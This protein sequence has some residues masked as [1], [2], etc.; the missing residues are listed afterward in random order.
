M[1][2]QVVRS[3]GRAATGSSVVRF[4]P[5]RLDLESQELRHDG[6]PVRLRHQPLTV[7]ALLASQPGRVLTREEIQLAVWG[8]DTHVDFEQGINYC[9]KEIRAALGDRA[10][11]PRYVETLARR[12]YRFIASVQ[13]GDT[14]EAPRAEA[15]PRPRRVGIWASAGAAVALVSVMALLAARLADRP[16]PPERLTVAVLPFENLSGDPEQDY[17]SEGLTE[18]VIARLGRLEPARLSVIA[19]SVAVDYRRRERAVDALGEELGVD[20]VLEGSVRLP[21]GRV[22][23]T[24]RLVRTG[25]KTQ[26]WADNLDLEL[27]DVVEVQRLIAQS[28]AARIPLTTTARRGASARGPGKVDPEAYRLYLRGRYFWNKWSVSALRRSISHFEDAI[29]RQPDYALAHAGLADAYVALADQSPVDPADTLRRAKEA[30][31]R[32]VALDASL[33]EAHASVG[34][35]LGVHEFQWAAAEDELRRAI[36]LNPSYPTARQWYSQCLRATGRLDEALAQIRLAEEAAPLSLIVVHNLGMVRLHRG[37]LEQAAGR[38]R[39]AL[40]MDPQFT[41]ALMGLGRALMLQGDTAEALEVLE[42]AARSS[43]GNPR[44]E[45]SLAYGY[46]AVGRSADA[47]AILERLLKG[48]EGESSGRAYDAAVVQAGLGDVDGALA[49]LEHA[50]ESRDPALRWL[51]VDE[52]LAVLRPQPR[53]TAVVAEVGLAEP[54]VTVSASRR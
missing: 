47:R 53:W 20:Y 33:A 54:P 52:R 32:A 11:S 23:V 4:G 43:H 2:D 3:A 26:V 15:Q 41:P 46:A 5:F 10:E 34:V 12:G 13:S 48:G 25:D 22:M 19:R 24:T 8:E 9:V 7:L 29:R 45:A 37:E 6:A 17:F 39:A 35:V 18:E 1:S 49:S 16:A 44:Y 51:L 14:G 50:L 31:L 42:R 28:V 21:A 30:A 36:D 38:F 40:E 27:R